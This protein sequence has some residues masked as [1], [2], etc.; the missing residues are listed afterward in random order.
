MSKRCCVSSAI[1]WRVGN[2][3]QLREFP[4]AKLVHDLA[5]FSVAIV[6]AFR[7]LQGA[8]RIQHRSREAGMDERRLQ[9]GDEA[10]ASEQGHEPRQ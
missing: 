1:V 10:V 4:A 3:L 9:R 8:K 2:Q 6:V 7:R 5:R